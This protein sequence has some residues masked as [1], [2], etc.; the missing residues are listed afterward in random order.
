[1]I[2]LIAIVKA[3]NVLRSIQI[4]VIL[5]CVGTDIITRIK[6]VTITSTVHELPEWVLPTIVILIIIIVF[7]AII[8][9]L[10]KR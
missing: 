5:T 6:F 1:M 9:I 10:K 7:I 3:T 2:L 8:A 4:T